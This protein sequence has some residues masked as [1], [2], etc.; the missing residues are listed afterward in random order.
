MLMKS[1]SVEEMVDFQ[2]KFYQ[3]KVWNSH[4]NG[5]IDISKYD[6]KVKTNEMKRMVME[7]VLSEY[8]EIQEMTILD[9][10]I[11]INS[12]GSKRELTQMQKLITIKLKQ[13]K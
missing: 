4:M 9:D 1:M 7:E 10:F 8:N 12:D 6:D 5:Y 13:L 3:N 11:S 2:K